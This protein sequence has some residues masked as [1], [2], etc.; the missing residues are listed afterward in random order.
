MKMNTLF[1]VKHDLKLID[2]FFNL[3]PLA[4]MQKILKTLYQA[5]RFF[6][7]LT[8]RIC[9]HSNILSTCQIFTSSAKICI[10]AVD[11]AKFKF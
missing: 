11:V 3:S 2:S 5:R 6:F 8:L 1:S 10:E 4:I 9:I 7:F